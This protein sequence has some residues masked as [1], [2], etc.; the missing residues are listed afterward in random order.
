L[1]ALI[2]QFSFTAD[3]LYLSNFCLFFH[4]MNRA[5]TL[6]DTLAH[7]TFLN[8]DF[9]AWGCEGSYVSVSSKLSSRSQLE[10]W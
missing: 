1:K 10:E 5:A 6:K 9:T 8:I 4:R 7:R 2:Y 3:K